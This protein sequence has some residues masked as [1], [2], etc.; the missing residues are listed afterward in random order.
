MK[1]TS[2][3][4]GSTFYVYGK[5]TMTECTVVE[6]REKAIKISAKTFISSPGVNDTVGDDRGFAWVPKKA[7][8]MTDTEGVVRWAGWFNIQY[9]RGAKNPSSPKPVSSSSF[10]GWDGHSRRGAAAY[11]RQFEFEQQMQAKVEDRGMYEPGG[12]YYG[13]D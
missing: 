10:R 6:E 11:E 5:N 2:I 9:R 7:I 4:T 13:I 1:K 8:Q 12:M 3:S